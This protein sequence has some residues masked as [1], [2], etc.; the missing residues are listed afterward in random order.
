MLL[1][2]LAPVHLKCV[3]ES[4]TVASSVMMSGSVVGITTTTFTRAVTQA[5]QY[6]LFLSVITV[7]IKIA[8]EAVLMVMMR[9]TVRKKHVS[10]K[11]ILHV[12]TN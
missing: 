2:V 9:A 11:D 12:L 5:K 6:L 10:G 3:M 4:V 8:I 1:S 7:K